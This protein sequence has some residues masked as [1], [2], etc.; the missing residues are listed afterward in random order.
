MTRTYRDS[1]TVYSK[2]HI[3]LYGS[4]PG[5]RRAEKTSSGYTWFPVEV[6]E[7]TNLLT[8]GNHGTGWNLTRATL[9]IG[10]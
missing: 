7:E 4:Y 10:S 6:P 1:P 3:L 9:Y 8:S 2:W 5:H